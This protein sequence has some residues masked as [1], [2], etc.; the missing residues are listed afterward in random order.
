MTLQGKR[1]LVTGGSRG[2][3]Y[4][5]C[6]IFLENGADVLAVSRDR[7]KLD[8][9]QRELSGL[10]VLQADVSA[11]A[12]NDRIAEWVQRLLGRA[13]RAGQQRRRVS[14]GL[15]RAVRHPGRGV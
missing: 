7:A 15:P 11:A 5:I 9:A 10:R 2:I 6:K 14:S 13:R 3:G 12:D 1:T 4:E 8:Q